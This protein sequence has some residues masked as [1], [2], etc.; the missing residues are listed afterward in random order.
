MSPTP[1]IGLH[2]AT[3]LM[4]LITLIVATTALLPQIKQGLAILRDVFLWVALIGIVGFVGFVGWERLLHERMGNP[5]DVDTI[6]FDSGISEPSISVLT[7]E[8]S[9][10]ATTR[11]ADSMDPLH[12][13]S[14]E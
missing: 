2:T 8:V 13:F 12:Q 9:R 3:L 11:E 4:C 7:K 10:P 14:R 6:E 5:E 1:Q